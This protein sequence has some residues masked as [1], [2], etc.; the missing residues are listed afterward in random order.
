M[1]QKCMFSQNLCGVCVHPGVT[2]KLLT[3]VL[4]GV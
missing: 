3:V 2:N 4:Y 1:L